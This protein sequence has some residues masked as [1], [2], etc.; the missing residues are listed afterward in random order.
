MAYIRVYTKDWNNK[1]ADSFYLDYSYDSNKWY[2][3]N[4][5]NPILSASLEEQ[6]IKNPKFIERA[7]GKVILMAEFVSEQEKKVF[8]DT[9]NF[10]IGRAHV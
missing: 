9:D 4:G 8:F 6:R 7:D 5:N 3:F 1:E 2:C 10:K